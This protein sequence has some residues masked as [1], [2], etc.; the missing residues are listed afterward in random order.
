MSG[1]QNKQKR[2][3]LPARRNGYTQKAKI[4]KHKIFIRTGEYEDGTLGEVFLDTHKDGATMRAVLNCLAIAVSLGLQHGVPLEEFVEAFTFTKF[5]P[6]GPVA[7]HARLKF[8]TSL[9]DLVFRD[10]AISYL[11][12]DDLA[13]VHNVP[14]QR[15]AIPEFT[16]QS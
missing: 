1:E 8:C 4:G 7:C 15:E 2:R 16:E 14:A 5:E 12:R 3:D 10:L 9:V 11:K 6:S 13:H